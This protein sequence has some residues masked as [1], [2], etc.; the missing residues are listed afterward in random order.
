VNNPVVEY[1]GTASA[2]V[3]WSGTDTISGSG[4]RGVSFKD[5]GG[6]ATHAVDAQRME[7][8]CFIENCSFADTDTGVRVTDSYWSWLSNIDVWADNGD[9]FV[10]DDS[11]GDVTYFPCRNLNARQAGSGS[12]LRVD[13]VDVHLDGFS[14]GATTID[15]SGIVIQNAGTLWA[16]HAYIESPGVNQTTPLG[17]EVTGGDAWVYG[18]WAKTRDGGVAVKV[19]D[20]GAA[21]VVSGMSFEVRDSNNL[22]QNHVESS[23]P[24]FDVAYPSRVSPSVNDDFD[25]N[26][27]VFGGDRE[28]YRDRRYPTDLST[29]TGRKYGEIRFDDGTNTSRTYTACAWDAANDTWY[30]LDGS[31]SFGGSN[32]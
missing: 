23:S 1:T 25:I 9:A 24:F 17:L 12:A 2:I 21:G 32:A 15:Q 29:E 10:F 19:T 20:S 28:F 22:P 31:T 16:S 6:N 7:N 18:G 27:R 11:A 4:I 3:D 5:T 14:T 30:P 13:G 26:G 8:Q